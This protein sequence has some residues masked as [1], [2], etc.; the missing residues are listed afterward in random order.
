MTPF[1]KI[2]LTYGAW[3]VICGLA[4]WFLARWSARRRLN[5]VVLALLVP[6]ALINLAQIAYILTLGE[7]ILLRP[8]NPLEKWLQHTDFVWYIL[9]ALWPFA[10][11]IGIAQ[12][13]LRIAS[14]PV[15]ARWAAFGCSLGIA[16][17]T[18]LILIFVT[19]G[20]AGACL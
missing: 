3:L 10:T 13:S 15:L 20:L 11:A 6:I 8:R 5:G 9:F 16:A 14:R 12:T 7:S 18:P 19:C 1:Q 4:A 2:G 17:L